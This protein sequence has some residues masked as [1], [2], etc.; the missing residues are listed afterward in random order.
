MNLLFM[1]DTLIGAKFKA[2]ICCA[3]A[4]TYFPQPVKGW[5][6]HRGLGPLLFSNSGVGSFTSRK[7]KSVKVLW[8][9][10]YS[11]SSLSEKTRKSKHLQMSFLQRQHFLVSYLKTLSVGPAGVWT[12]DLSLARSALS[13]LS[14]LGGGEILMSTSCFSGIMGRSIPLPSS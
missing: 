11:F 13:Q 7:N 10:T 8:D 6:H 14:W 9:G 2:Y 5:P 12:H 3:F 4:V 1:I